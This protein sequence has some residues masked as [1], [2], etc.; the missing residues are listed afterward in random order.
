MAPLVGLSGTCGRT[1]AGAFVDS[2]IDCLHLARSYAWCVCGSG[3]VGR[4]DVIMEGFE[5][6]RE[7]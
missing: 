4:W 1:Q 7:V 3:D 2:V 6:H 5:A